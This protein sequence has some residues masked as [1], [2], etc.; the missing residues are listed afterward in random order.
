MELAVQIV[1]MVGVFAGVAALFLTHAIFQKQAQVD[2]FLAYTERFDKLMATWPEETWRSDQSILPPES[3]E[4][5]MGVLKYLNLCS[6]ELYLYENKLLAKKVW[7]IWEDEIKRTL[8]SLLMRR[9]WPKLKQEF[10]CFPEFVCYVEGIQSNP[11][12]QRL[13]DR[14]IRRKVGKL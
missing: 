6:Q 11:V 13:L 7:E 1:T 3:K 8:A 10:R 14:A 4:V 9:E 2:V 12:A 5:Q